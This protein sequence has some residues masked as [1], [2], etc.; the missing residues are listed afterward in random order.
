LGYTAL[1]VV[2]ALSARVVGS[3][4]RARRE[5]PRTRAALTPARLAR[6]RPRAAAQTTE[7]AA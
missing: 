2:C 4:I 3:A 7:N 5:K 1:A 6:F